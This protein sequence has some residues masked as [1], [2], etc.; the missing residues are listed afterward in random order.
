MPNTQQDTNQNSQDAAK[1]CQDVA[2]QR[3]RIF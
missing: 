3:I 1:N 2:T